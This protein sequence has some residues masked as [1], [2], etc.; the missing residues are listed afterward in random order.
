VKITD[1]KP[2]DV[3]IADAGFTCVEAGPVAIEEDENG[4]LYF[5]CSEGRHYLDGQTDDGVVVGLSHLKAWLF[6]TVAG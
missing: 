2:G 1:I 6:D 5:L 3:L 4:E